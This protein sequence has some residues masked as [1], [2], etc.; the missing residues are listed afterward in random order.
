MHAAIALFAQLI[1]QFLGYPPR[2]LDRIGHPVIWYGRIIDWLDT[3]LNRA[4]RSPEVRRQA[5]IVM[6]VLLLLATLIVTLAI[7]SLTRLV[8]FGWLIDAVLASALLAGKQL[9]DAVRD[10]ARALRQS[11]EAGRTAVSQIVGRDP[12]ALDESG[13]SRAAIESLAENASDGLIAP[14]FW[15]LLLGLPGIALYKAI[16]TADSMVG[17]LN[18]RYRDFGWASARLDD[19]VNW[20][21]A[22]L[23]ALLYAG[24]AFFVRGGNPR[25]AWAAARRDAPFHTSPNAGWPEAASAGALGFALG[26]ARSYEGETLYLPTMGQGRSDLGPDDI[27]S[28]LNLYQAM[29]LVAFGV[30]VLLTVV[31]F[32]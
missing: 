23:T 11:L 27:D 1:E 17:H 2:L 21:A 20:P 14:L 13:V 3:R 7:T 4:E 22:R 5:G 29:R 9:H 19:V 32:R 30:T 15:L 6:L 26:G 18:D 28:A 16:N 24:A 10:V 12:E 31:F 8:P 25:E